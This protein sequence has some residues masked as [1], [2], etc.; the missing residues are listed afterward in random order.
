VKGRWGS[1]AELDYGKVYST[2][3]GA[4]FLPQDVRIPRR[5]RRFMQNELAQMQA[6]MGPLARLDPLATPPELEAVYF[7]A[8]PAD[9]P[10]RPAP[11]EETA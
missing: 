6:E 8:P 2:L 4:G 11:A 10:A 3:I 9:H 5:M 1:Y 7:P